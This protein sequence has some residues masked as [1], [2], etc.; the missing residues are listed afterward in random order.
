MKVFDHQQSLGGHVTSPQ[1]QL[2]SNTTNHAST[3][4]EETVEEL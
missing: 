1:G 3:R 2:T 4:T